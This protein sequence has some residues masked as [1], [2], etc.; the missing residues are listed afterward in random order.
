MLTE[1]GDSAARFFEVLSKLPVAKNMELARWSIADGAA[2]LQNA[3]GSAFP[4]AKH[5]TDRNH[6]VRNC[7]DKIREYCGARWEEVWRKV[8]KGLL[9]D[10][11]TGVRGVIQATTREEA[12]ARI[13]ELMPT[14][15]EP[16]QR[17][18]GTWK[19]R[20]CL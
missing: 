18:F 3:M 8:R 1:R 4:H 7:R 17:Y 11:A 19:R 12:E 13:E 14:W 16:F 6:V 5:A 9:G 2:S 15:P 20:V 10:T